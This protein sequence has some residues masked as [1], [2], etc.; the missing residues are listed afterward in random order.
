MVTNTEYFISE[1]ETFEFTPLDPYLGLPF[2][3]N[4]ELG[5]KYLLA[6]V[7]FVVLITGLYMRKIIL[8]YLRSPESMLGGINYLIWL[9]QMNGLIGALSMVIHLLEM[10]LPFSLRSVIG[11]NGCEWIGMTGCIYMSGAIVW[12]M[13]I[14]IYRFV[15][16]GFNGCI[17]IMSNSLYN[18]KYKSTC[19]LTLCGGKISKCFTTC[20]RVKMN[21]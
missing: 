4:L 18:M 3:Q 6:S 1:N 19:V 11:E 2:P 9:D 10:L 17:S 15:C 7:Y 21:N 20:F 16:L 13:A 8:S 12:S 14:A 5:W